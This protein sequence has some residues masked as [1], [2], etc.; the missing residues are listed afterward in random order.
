MAEAANILHQL[1]TAE[2]ESVRLGAARSVLE[3]GVRL[4]ESV[5]LEE[6]IRELVERVSAREKGYDHSQPTRAA[7]A[8]GGQS[9]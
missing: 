8:M 9:P 4:R 7:Q 5:E 2:S 1:L 6:Q 3:L